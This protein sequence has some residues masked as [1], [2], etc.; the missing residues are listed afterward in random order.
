MRVKSKGGKKRA[1]SWRAGCRCSLGPGHPA[2]VHARLIIVPLSLCRYQET[3][4]ETKSTPGAPA[5]PSTFRLGPI[6]PT[7]STEHPPPTTQ[8]TH[9]L[10]FTRSAT[11]TQRFTRHTAQRSTRHTERTHRVGDSWGPEPKVGVGASPSQPGTTFLRGDMAT[12]AYEPGPG[13]S[14]P[15]CAC[16]CSLCGWYGIVGGS[17]GTQ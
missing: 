10:R 1:G 7:H 3:K 6:S 9:S 16:S 11:G 14:V 15:S 12:T 5:A 2:N 13:D 17:T 8:N 4:E